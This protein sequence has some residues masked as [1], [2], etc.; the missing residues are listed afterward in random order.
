MGVALIASHYAR[1][2]LIRGKRKNSI[3]MYRGLKLAQNAR[4][5]YAEESLIP[6]DCIDRL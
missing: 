3:A 4:V 1:I 5:G 2:A 6:Q